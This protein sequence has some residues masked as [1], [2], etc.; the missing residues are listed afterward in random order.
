[1]AFKK[2]SSKKKENKND[3]LFKSIFIAYGILLLH[4]ILLAALGLLVLFFRGVINYMTW[5]FLGGATMILASA[6]YFLRKI[7]QEKN[8][9]SEILKLP[10]FHNKDIEIKL[11]GGAASFKVG[12]Q[13]HGEA[14][15][16]QDLHNLQLENPAKSRIHDL[17][18]LSRLYENEMITKT[19]YETLK[20]ELLGSNK[21]PQENNF[22]DNILDVP[23]LIKNDTDSPDER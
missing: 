18:E 10:E 6:Y 8:T 21:K 7:K 12:N 3:G 19:E 15:P 22:T 11:L 9:I 23:H 17:G 2:K 4:V 5:I 16:I 14:I 13:D 1:M 20:A